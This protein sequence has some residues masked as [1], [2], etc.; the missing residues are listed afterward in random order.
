MSE[1]LRLAG[2]A[3]QAPDSAATMPAER[4]A[5]LECAPLSPLPANGRQAR[6][7]LDYVL[8][9]ADNVPAGAAAKAAWVPL[10]VHNGRVVHVVL[11][12]HRAL[13]QGRG[14]C[15]D[16]PWCEHQRLQCRRAQ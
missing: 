10:E 3:R 1:G 11:D 12:G 2:E 4:H 7:H 6:A 5:R 14:E 16:F 15:S 8:I 9:G 13:Q